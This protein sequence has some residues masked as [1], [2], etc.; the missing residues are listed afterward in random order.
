MRRCTGHCCKT[1]T[2]PMSPDELWA[3]FH[4]WKIGAGNSTPMSNRGDETTKQI[5][6]EIYLIAP[7]V[8][9]LGYKKLPYKQVRPEE[10]VER[11]HL[12]TCK[13]FD[14][15]TNN[16]GIYEHRPQMCRDYPYGMSCNYRACT[17]TSR[18]NKPETKKQRVER[19]KVL[20]EEKKGEA[21]KRVGA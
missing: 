12:Y 4:R 18:K 15:K 2:L 10:K 16:C 19:L 7:M 8:I 1:F 5:I 13:H 21:P 14:T 9:Y 3:A 6:G 17:W 11:H 20:K